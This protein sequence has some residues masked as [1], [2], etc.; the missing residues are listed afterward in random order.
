MG[1]SSLPILS[2]FA[3]RNFM[4]NSRK[5]LREGYNKYYGS[6]FKL[7]CRTNGCTSFPG[8]VSSG[9]SGAGMMNHDELSLSAAFS[10]ILQ[11]EIIRVADG[12]RLHNDAAGHSPAFPVVFLFSQRVSRVAL[13]I[14]PSL[15]QLIS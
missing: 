7:P 1:G 12:A 11:T 15:T 5:L 3:G 10:K 8:R 2:Y 13:R 9:R 4:Q 14:M 6:V